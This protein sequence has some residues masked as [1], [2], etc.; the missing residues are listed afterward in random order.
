MNMDAYLG[1]RAGDGPS[2]EDLEY[3]PDFLEMTIAAQPGQERQ[4]GSEIVAGEEPDYKTVAKKALAVLERSHDLRAAVILAQAQTR[5]EG[6]EGLAGV[7]AFI[8]ACL[9]TWWDTVHP[10]LDAD[11]DNDPTMRINAVVGLADTGG[12]LRLVRLAPLTESRTF[13]RMTLRDVAISEGEASGD[14][15]GPDAAAVAAAFR[16]TRPEVLKLR[17]EAARGA[18]E[19]ARAI[20]AVFDDR[21]PGDGP[22]LDPLIRMLRKAVTKLAAAVGE[23]EEAVAAA[24]GGTDETPTEVSGGVDPQRGPSVPGTISTQADVVAALDRIMA[25]FARHEPSSPV[26]LLLAR[27]KRLVGADFLTIIN[28]MVP[29]GTDTVRGLGGIRAEE[30]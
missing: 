22:N 24:A 9:E 14:G 7:T 3:D 6:Y 20:S 5:L 19:D 13:G 15:G 30:D 27:A 28:D 23:P 25:Y 29:E 26:P 8:R 12:L 18:L 10:Q 1:P 16:E 2:G 21:T 11:D 17:L 4:V